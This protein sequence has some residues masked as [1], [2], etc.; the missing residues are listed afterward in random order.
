MSPSLEHRRLKITAG[1]LPDQLPRLK[2]LTESRVFAEQVDVIFPTSP[3]LL[4]AFSKFKTRHARG[5]ATLSAIF[6][7]A[8]AFVKAENSSEM[9]W[10]GTS[11]GACDDTW[12]IDARGQL[13]IYASERAY[14]RMGIPGAKLKFHAVHSDAYV[15]AVALFEVA[16]Q[17]AMLARVEAG[18]K[19]LDKM[20]EEE[21][22][23][24]WDVVCAATDPSASLSDLL[25]KLISHAEIQEITAERTQLD[26]VHVPSAQLGP[27]PS[28]TSSGD[29]KEDWHHRMS[30]LFEWV[31]L[32]GLDYPSTTVLSL[33]SPYTTPGTIPDRQ[34][35][36]SAL[37]RS[38]FASFF[39][40]RLGYYIWVMACFK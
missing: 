3:T 9:I 19:I 22:L 36:A 8:S 26:D 29:E 20:R 10:L 25:E 15:V 40:I 17:P 24:E 37:A 34:R 6:A 31:G 13:S 27:F 11:G 2:T 28:A 16:K 14:Q 5:K 38:A 33:I 4:S 39:A 12:C 1:S 23:G 18:L 32:V 35:H 21:G 30:S 7:R